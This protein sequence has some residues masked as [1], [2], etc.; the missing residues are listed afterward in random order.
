[1]TNPDPNQPNPGGFNK[2][3][4]QE[5]VIDVVEQIRQ[6]LKTM[7]GNLFAAA[8]WSNSWLHSIRIVALKGQSTP[9]HKATPGGYPDIHGFPKV[10]A[11][12]TNINPNAQAIK[13]LLVAYRQKLF[14]DNGL[15]KSDWKTIIRVVPTSD[16]ITPDASLGCGCGCS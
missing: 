9:G 13:R 5:P 3:K 8:N 7:H 6:D 16:G 10:K 12:E 4:N 11:T 14:A 2:I 1:M 15:T